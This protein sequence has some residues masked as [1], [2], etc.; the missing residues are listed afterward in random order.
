[1][2]MKI[3]QDLENGFINLNNLFKYNYCLSYTIVSSISPYDDDALALSEIFFLSILYTSM[4]VI[5][6]PSPIVSFVVIVNE[7][8]SCDQTA[9][10]FFCES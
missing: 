5:S 8:L 4:I 2:Y 9:V 7:F 1:M 10:D 6:P 3:A